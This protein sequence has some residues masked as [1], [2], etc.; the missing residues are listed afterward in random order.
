MAIAYNPFINYIIT[1]EQS[2]TQPLLDIARITT[3]NHVD[4]LERF[5]KQTQAQWLRKRNTERWDMDDPYR[6]YQEALLPLFEKLGLCNSIEPKPNHYTYALVLGNTAQ[7]IVQ[8]LTFL[9]RLSSKNTMVDYLVF[10]SGQ[11]IITQDEFDCVKN[12]VPTITA[13]LTETDMMIT[14][15]HHTS[16]APALKVLKL[17]VV[18]TPYTIT[19]LG[20]SLRPT[21]PDTITRWLSR[22]NPMAGS[23]LAISLQPFLPYQDAALRTLLPGTFNLEI[24]GP[25]DSEP[26]TASLYLDSLARWVYQELAWQKAITSITTY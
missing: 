3:I 9:Q 10:L 23:C 19:P 24:A 6:D 16:L 2:L 17:C 15:L 13:P 11:R 8:Q 22:Y 4:T 1:K 5:V 14:F 26:P 7:S 20:I 21:T 18:D 25:V 12:Y